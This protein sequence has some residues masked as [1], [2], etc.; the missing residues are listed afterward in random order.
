MWNDAWKLSLLVWDLYLDKNCPINANSF[1][2]KNTLQAFSTLA[3]IS[4]TILSP[5]TTLWLQADIISILQELC[6]QKG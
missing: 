1:K 6:P 5:Q 2:R 3:F 4:F